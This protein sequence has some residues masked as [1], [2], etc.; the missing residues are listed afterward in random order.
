M[1]NLAALSVA[2]LSLAIFPVA[3]LA[4]DEDAPSISV[5]GA[6][7]DAE[8]NSDLLAAQARRVV[9]V[10]RSAPAPASAEGIAPLADPPA[11]T[12]PVRGHAKAP[13]RPEAR[14]RHEPERCEPA[15]LHALPAI[16]HE[17]VGAVRAALAASGLDGAR[18]RL[19]PDRPAD[20]LDGHRRLRRSSS[21]TARPRPF[22]ISH[23]RTGCSS[24][25]AATAPTATASRRYSS[26]SSR[27]SA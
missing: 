13:R 6:Q 21:G 17:Q 2:A 16:R 25:S 7:T 27:N 5:V 19:R 12:D 22:G 20:Q 9:L 23:R 3:A 24:S 26:A 1:R 15:R 4:A 18:S 10:P 11:G 14:R 8:P